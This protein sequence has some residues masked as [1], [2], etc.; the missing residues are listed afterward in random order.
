MKI[1][2]EQY[3]SM[4]VV[5]GNITEDLFKKELCLL[6]T[7]IDDENKTK[8]QF[9]LNKTEALDLSTRINNLLNDKVAKDI[10]FSYAEGRSKL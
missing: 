1:R 10:G 9:V 6:L 2:I 3:G 4:I 8:S 7:M 5:T